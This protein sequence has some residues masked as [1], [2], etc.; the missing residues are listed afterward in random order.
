M[1]ITSSEI[2]PLT[3]PELLGRILELA[4]DAII[5]VDAQYRITLFNQGAERIFGYSAAE[6]IGR[7]LDLLLPARVAEVHRRHVGD[8]ERSSVPA[9][10]MAERGRI[11]GRRKDGSEF[12]AEASIAKVDVDGRKMFAVILRDV[13]ERVAAEQLIQASLREKETLLKEIHHRVKNNLQV[14]SSLLALQARTALDEGTRTVLLESQNRIHAMGLVHESLYKSSDLSRVAFHGYIQ[15]LAAYL[16]R[17]FS[18]PGD[19]ILLHTDLSQL[20][21]TLDAAVPCGLILNELISNSLKH[22]FP[23]DRPGKVRV[24]LY[25]RPQGTARLVVADDGAGLPED[26]D[27]HTSRTLGFRLI[28]TLAEQIGADVQIT[29][30]G[31]TEST[32]TF[33]IRPS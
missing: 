20:Y 29:S 31:G 21:L 6:A 13:A 14:V 30:R 24:G 32:L 28:R 10:P 19:R 18:V 25:E 27:W 9:R 8:F 12:P 15:E 2:S 1:F 17:A 4:D 33:S 23:G 26:V 5:S 22:A 3:S 11:L 16:F 7:P